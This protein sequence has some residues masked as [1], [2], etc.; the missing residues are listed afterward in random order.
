MKTKINNASISDVK[1][2]SSLSKEEIESKIIWA[3]AE[4]LEWEDF[5][6]L[7]KKELKKR[8]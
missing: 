6:L 3:K 2:I 1:P 8:K 7:C 5:I 4:I